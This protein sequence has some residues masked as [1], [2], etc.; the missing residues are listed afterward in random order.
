MKI[1]KHLIAISLLTIFSL[2][3]VKTVFAYGESVNLFPEI[4]EDSAMNFELGNLIS[5]AIQAAIVI[6]GLLTF[7]FLVWGGIEWLTSG[8]DKEK[9]EAARG[10]ITAAVIGLVIVVAAWAIMNVIGSFLNL[11]DMKSL[12]IPGINQKGTQSAVEVPAYQT[13]G[14]H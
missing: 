8:G 11:G 14:D 3:L 13:P 5:A 10:R 7:A 4:E 12:T 1:T 9:Y 2:V 6:A